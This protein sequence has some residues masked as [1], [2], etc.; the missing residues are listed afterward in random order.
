AQ[1][2]S[3]L[4]WRQLARPLGFDQGLGAYVGFYFVGNF[5]NLVLPTSV[6]GD[7]AR[8]WYLGRGTGRGSAA[9]MCVLA[10]RLIGLYVL[11]AMACVAAFVVP[12]PG[13]VIALVAAFGCGAVVG[14]V[15]LM[16]LARSSAGRWRRAE[17]LISALSFYCRSPRLLLSASLLSLAVQVL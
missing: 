13:W 4:R 3:S 6:G 7:V 8:A 15:F 1:I 11:V 10:D 2:V 9:A 12:L 5:F 14:L 17:E 16:L